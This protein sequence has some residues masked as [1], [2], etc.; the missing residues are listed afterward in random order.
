MG[1]VSKDLKIKKLGELKI[2]SRASTH[3]RGKYEDINTS[4]GIHVEPPNSGDPI[5][6]D[7]EEMDYS[8][9]DDGVDMFAQDP[10]HELMETNDVKHSTLD[11]N[12]Q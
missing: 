2:A 8:L 3:R 5:L 4:K 9:D 11:A 1:T 6:L 12:A 7:E 10:P